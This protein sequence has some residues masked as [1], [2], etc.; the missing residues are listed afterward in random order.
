MIFHAIAHNI[1][2]SQWKIAKSPEQQ[3]VISGMT[4]HHFPFMGAVHSFG[5]SFTGFGTVATIFMLLVAALLWVTGGFANA[6]PQISIKILF[7]LFFSLAATCIEEFI[8]FF[9]FA[10]II[11]L[12]A[13]LLTGAA[14]LGLREAKK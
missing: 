3:A 11:T 14:A 13:A 5:D 6:Q 4:D 7:L 12:L 2:M 8:Y 1:G 10:A 9:P